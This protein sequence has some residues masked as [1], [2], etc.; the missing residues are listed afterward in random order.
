[1]LIT[2]SAIDHKVL[3]RVLAD[4][5]KLIP[6][7][8]SKPGMIQLAD[9]RIYG[10][11]ED[12]LFWYEVPTLSGHGLVVVR[13]QLDAFVNLLGLLPSSQTCCIARDDDY[14]VFQNSRSRIFLRNEP[15][16]PASGGNDNVLPVQRHHARMPGA[17]VEVAQL[18][19]HRGQC[20]EAS[21]V[22]GADSRHRQ[23]PC[24]CV[25]RSSH[26]RS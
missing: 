8:K 15:M 19:Q 13:E 2:L 22:T 11:A 10:G 16:Q 6:R 21:F 5:C 23:T 18:T 7:N 26:R 12:L 25:G 14:H 9:G 3:H 1:M 20:L 4:A 17:R 24:S